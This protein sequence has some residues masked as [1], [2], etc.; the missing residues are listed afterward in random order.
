MLP[1]LQFSIQREP[2]HLAAL[3]SDK[4]PMCFKASPGKKARKKKR[5][6][7]KT[8]CKHEKG[9]SAEKK[10]SSH[11]IQVQGKS[12]GKKGHPHENQVATRTSPSLVGKDVT[13]RSRTH[14]ISLDFSISCS[15]GFH[16]VP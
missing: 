7:G 9:Q 5:D 6:N 2:G 12:P 1:A 8:R 11:S 4:G 13:G 15:K 3:K 14:R 10:A 16:N